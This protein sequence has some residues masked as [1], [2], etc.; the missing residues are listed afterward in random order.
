MNVACSAPH[1]PDAE[2]GSAG[3]HQH[4]SCYPAD[5][6]AASGGRAGRD[7]QRESHA[8]GDGQ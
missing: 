2:A 1:T 5:Y 6:G 3:Q 8:A 7:E 4:S